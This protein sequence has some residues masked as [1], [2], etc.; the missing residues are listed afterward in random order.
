MLLPDPRCPQC[1]VGGGRRVHWV[2]P[3]GHGG[4]G[5]QSDRAREVEKGGVQVSGL[6]QSV[7][8]DGG[9]VAEMGSPGRG[10]RYTWKQMQ[11]RQWGYRYEGEKEGLDLKSS[12]SHRIDRKRE[13]IR[14]W[15]E[16][17][18]PPLLCSVPWN[19]GSF[20][21]TLSLKLLRQSSLVALMV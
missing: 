3:A 14:H 4:V 13:I 11:H 17:L 5:G 15:Q 18:K 2:E 7:D 10:A 16:R 21:G 8:E 12:S 20:G 6:A 9:A 1:S 19:L